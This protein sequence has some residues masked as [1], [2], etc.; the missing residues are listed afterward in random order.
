MKKHLVLSL[1]LAVLAG[2]ASA[3]N[4][5]YFTLDMTPSNEPTPG[6]RVLVD[7]IRVSEAV[8]HKDIMIKTSPTE[9]EYYATA[10]W[11]ASLG[12]LVT[13][14][15]QEEFGDTAGEGELLLLSGRLMAFEQVDVAGGAE[16]HLKL[17]VT[18]QGA[19]DARTDP[20]VLDRTYNITVPADSASPEA[21]VRALSVCVEKAAAEI[22][23]D[24]AD[25]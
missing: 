24:M 17:A 18:V 9:V 1:A 11:A 16:A 8:T 14:K 22:E 10:Q 6:L 15:L 2:C 21:V 20:P 3:P 12:E 4:I 7:D 13:E 5:Q 19:Q 23:A 25:R